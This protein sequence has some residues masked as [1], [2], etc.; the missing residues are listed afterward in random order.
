[1]H[2][3]KPSFF[4]PSKMGFKSC[5]GLDPFFYFTGHNFGVIL[6]YLSAAE[7]RITHPQGAVYPR[8]EIIDDRSVLEATFRRVFPQRHREK[9][10]SIRDGANKEVG[11]LLDA[12]PMDAVSREVLRGEL[13]RRYFTPSVKKISALSQEAGMWKF[14]VS[15]QRGDFIFFVRNW[16]ESAIELNPGRWVIYSVDGA[17]Y[18]IEQMDALD[19]GSQKLLD[20]LL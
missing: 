18:E 6:K 14:T 1:M 15:T 3:A 16:R 20:Q 5:K 11:V 12:E 10:I 19:H 2:A 7:I 17:R 4:A 9:F 8:V 13:D